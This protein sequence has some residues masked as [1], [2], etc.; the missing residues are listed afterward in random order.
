[1]CQA[2]DLGGQWGQ[3]LEAFTGIGTF[4]QGN[5]ELLKGSKLESD[6]TRFAF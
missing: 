1:M 6:T 3:N 2:P 5:W 4:P